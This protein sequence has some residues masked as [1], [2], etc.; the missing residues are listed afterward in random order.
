MSAYRDKSASMSHEINSPWAFDF[1]LNRSE[2][3]ST[4][5]ATSQWKT[6]WLY[7]TDFS[8]LKICLQK[9]EP[10]PPSPSFLH[11]ATSSST[12]TINF[13]DHRSESHQPFLQCHYFLWIKNPIYKRQSFVLDLRLS[14]TP[15]LSLPSQLPASSTSALNHINTSC[16]AHIS[17][18]I[19]SDLPEA[20]PLSQRPFFF[21]FATFPTT[22]KIHIH[23]VSPVFIRHCIP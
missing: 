17:S 3:F 4:A 2:W 7:S 14:S 22:S 20:D 19:R 16:I 8:E 5:L 23:R 13:I 18:E 10:R 6:N 12:S 11:I 1:D 15:Q 21:H 9:G